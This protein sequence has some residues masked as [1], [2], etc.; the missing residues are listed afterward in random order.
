MT[1]TTGRAAADQFTALGLTDADYTDAMRI[2]VKQGWSNL[3]VDAKVADLRDALAAVTTPVITDTD[4]RAGLPADATDEQV[5]VEVAR[6]RRNAGV[7]AWRQRTRIQ[8]A[9][10]ARGAKFAAMR[11]KANR[12]LPARAGTGTG[13]TV[14]VP[15]RV[16]A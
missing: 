5:A 14:T 3:P 13:D 6:L 7:N 8:A 16:T 1:R 11:A 2:A 9:L 10:D 15:L 12:A 4:A